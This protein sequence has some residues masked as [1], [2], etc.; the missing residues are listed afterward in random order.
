[1]TDFDFTNDINDT[2]ENTGLLQ[3]V[4]SV[5][6]ASA[7]DYLLPNQPDLYSKINE[8]IELDHYNPK[9]LVWRVFLYSYLFSGCDVKATKP[10]AKKF[11]KKDQEAYSVPTSLRHKSA[12]TITAKNNIN[13]L[14]CFSFFLSKP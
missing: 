13:S 3:V 14:I 6:V 8:V 11:F 4:R 7:Q 5:T 9:Y 1:M 10:I 12:K 2:Q